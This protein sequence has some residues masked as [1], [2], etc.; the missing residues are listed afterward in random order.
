MP[1]NTETKDA[2][3]QQETKKSTEETGGEGQAI[4]RAARV[5]RYDRPVMGFPCWPSFV[6]VFLNNKQ[7]N[8]KGSMG[9]VFGYLPHW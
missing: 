1:P 8:W 9:S 2:H 6:F 4:Q 7:A 3:P 5:A